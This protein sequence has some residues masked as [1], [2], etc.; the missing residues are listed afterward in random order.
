MYVPGHHIAGV[1]KVVWANCCNC[2]TLWD[3][4]LSVCTAGLGCLFGWVMRGSAF[5]AIK[6]LPLYKRRKVN[7]RERKQN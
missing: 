7:K 4:Y 3:T 1:T 5:Q 6:M 2:R